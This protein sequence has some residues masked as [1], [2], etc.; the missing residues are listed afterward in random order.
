MGKPF[1]PEDLVADFGATAPFVRAGIRSLYEALVENGKYALSAAPNVSADGTR[2]VPATAAKLAGHYGMRG[3]EIRPP[4]LLFAVKSYFAI[5]L[6]QLA[7]RLCPNASVA[8]VLSD[9]TFTWYASVR[10]AP[11]E[12]L[13]QNLTARLDDY[14]P[15][16]ISPAGG[17]GRDLLK[18]LYQQLFP[19]SVRHDLGEYYTPDWLAEHVLTE[20]GYAGDPNQRLLDPACGSGTFLVAAINRIRQF[21]DEIPPRRRPDKTDL[22]RKILENVVGFDLNPL[23]VL[24]AKTNYLIAM[25]DLIGDGDEVA[26]PVHRRDSILGAAACEEGF[27][28]IAG[29]PPWVNWDFLPAETR[30]ALIPLY[31]HEYRLFPHTGN[32]ARHGS[33]KIDVAGLMTYVT[34]DRHLRDGGVLGFVVTESLLKTDAGKGFRR[35]RLPED[36][37]LQVYRADDMV[38]LNPFDNTSNRTAVVFIQRGEETTY[39]VQY[40]RWSVASQLPGGLSGMTLQ[41]VLQHTTRHELEASPVDKTDRQSLW[42]T[43]TRD[44]RAVLAKMLGP[45][46]YESHL[47]V[48]SG[49]ANAVYWVQRLSK[50]E[51]G[52]CRIRNLL[53]GAKRRAEQVEAEIESDRL[54]P[55]LRPRDVR[56]W[57]ARCTAHL[58][59]A[60]DP[61]RPAHGMSEIELKHRSPLC[62]AYLRRFHD[63]LST[64]SAYRKYLQPHGQPFYALYDIKAYSFTAWKVVWPRIASEVKAAVV[65]RE[66]GKCILPQETLCLVGL[67]CEEEAHYLAGVMNSRLFNFAVNCYSQSGGK[68]FASTHV[69]RQISVPRYDAGDRSHGR[70]VALATACRDAASAE[71]GDELAR[72][73]ADLDAAVSDLWGITKKGRAALRSALSEGRP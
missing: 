12:E 9:D 35:F 52:T 59:V 41:D 30:S 65:G 37:P 32:R 66:S 8:D 16:S 48:N 3:E 1:T 29:N 18:P 50:N 36:V 26:I 44:Q 54:Y 24:A 21:H 68:S 64:R 61:N 62:Y 38:R 31:Q 57:S 19:K 34:A 71:D 60:Q 42:L 23:A 51:N 55:L 28:Y 4:E 22:A 49:G 56:R 20:L 47:G 58:V 17:G 53:G 72:L 46:V 7:R 70:I 73:E 27:D 25:G 13:V 43:A 39:P 5:F 10:S 11:I 67:D 2:S 6:E 15:H 14:D 33:A 45:S 63:L 69:L 40:V